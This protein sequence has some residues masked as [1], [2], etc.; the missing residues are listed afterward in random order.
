MVAG[1]GPLAGCYDGA[2]EPEP[3]R[4]SP[5]GLCYE[6]TNTCDLT[7]PC[8]PVGK[9]CYDPVDPC[10][11]V[12]CNGHGTCAVDADEGTPVCMCEL[13]YSNFRYTLYCEAV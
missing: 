12:F 10:R 6:E 3:P 2:D 13:G 9:Y 8:D 1:C 4:G 11:G 7:F 5:G